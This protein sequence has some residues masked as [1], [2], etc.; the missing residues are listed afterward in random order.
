MT[1]SW[2]TVRV[3]ATCDRHPAHRVVTVRVLLLHR[4][5]GSVSV[6]DEWPGP[7]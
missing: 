1:L 5:D 7:S 6:L 3:M 4:T 2:R